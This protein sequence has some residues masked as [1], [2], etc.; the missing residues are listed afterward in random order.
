MN[1]NIMSKT[2]AGQIWA[3]S[4]RIP[5]VLILSFIVSACASTGSPTTPARFD[6]QQDIGFTITEQAHASSSVRT[7]YEEALSF[8]EQGNYDQGI[9]MLEVV[10]AAAPNLSASRIDLGVAYHRVGKLEAAEKNL[11]LALELNP[12][13]PIAQT[14]LGIVYRK[15]GRFAEARQSY[16]AA[17]SLYP[18]YHYARRNL[19]ILCDL[20]LADLDCALFNYEAYIAMVPGD[21]EAT[22]WIADLRMRMAQVK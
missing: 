5:S 7:E 20:Y 18:G 13:H 4:C 3:T 15:T 11:L 8:L 22:I 12:K 16:Q 6:V 21:D 14:E 1:K 9:A 2:I 10:V 19:A 17:L